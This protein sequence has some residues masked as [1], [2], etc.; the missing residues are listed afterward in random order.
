MGGLIR[1]IGKWFSGPWPN[2]RSGQEIR[3]VS[4][5]QAHDVIVEDKNHE[6]EKNEHPGLLCPFDL[7][8]AKGAA[9]QP[10]NHEKQDMSSV[11]NRDGKQIQDCQIDA[12]QGDEMDQIEQCLRW[13]AGLPS[14]QSESDLPRSCTETTPSRSFPMVTTKSLLKCQ[15]WTRL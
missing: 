11:Q 8:L 2:L 14:A 5:Y 9:E 15:V 3:F 4:G 6:H 13:P 7:L 1:R 10:F 12:D